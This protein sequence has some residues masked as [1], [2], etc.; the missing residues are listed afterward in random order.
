LR[1]K[2]A[3]GITVMLVDGSATL[4]Y[5][6]GILLKRLEF[7]VILAESAEEALKLIENDLPSII[8]TDIQL[9]GMSC[10][11]FVKAIKNTDSTKMIP[12]IV[13][14]DREDFAS[15]S[16]CLNLGCCD[17]LVKHV[18]PGHLYRTIHKVLAPTPRAHIR[19]SVPLKVVVGDGTSLGGAERTEYTTTISEGGLYLRTLFPRPKDSCTPVKIFIKERAV[20]ARAAVVYSRFMERGFFREPGM[21]MKFIEIAKDDRNFVR[22]FI[23]EQLTS[24]IVMGL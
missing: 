21:G 12:V 24:D 18:E 9:P 20:K 17:Y 3:N 15:K 1:D 4:R 11:E 19:L 13:L 7:T 6:F 2:Y 10:E 8:I 14:A 22:H 5:Y 16:A 23:K